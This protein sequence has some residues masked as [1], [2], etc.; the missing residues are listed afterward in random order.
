MKL[1]DGCR[2]GN[3]NG[4]SGKISED[5]IKSCEIG[6]EKISFMWKLK[7]RNNVRQ[8]IVNGEIQKATKMIETSFRNSC[9]KSKYL[10]LALKVQA[11]FEIVKK[12]D[13]RGLKFLRTKLK[14]YFDDKI[15]LLSDEINSVPKEFSVKE[16]MK[17]FSNGEK[18]KNIW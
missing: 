12:D 3:S 9:K 7:E 6:P 2:Q 8:L 13:L 11:F 17:L 1:S 5:K 4:K 14:K 10:V 18:F 15:L 16:L